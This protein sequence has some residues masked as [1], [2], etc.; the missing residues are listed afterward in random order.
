MLT[1]ADRA[2]QTG[3]TKMGSASDRLT[4]G[5]IAAELGDQMAWMLI[6]GFGGTRVYIPLEPDDSSPLVRVLGRSAA[7]ALGH[8]F[9]GEAV[10]IPLHKTRADRRTDRASILRLRQQGQSVAAIARRIGCSER[11]IYHVLSAAPRP[12]ASPQ[13]RRA[14]EA[15]PRA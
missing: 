10:D 14:Q 2:A 15:L 3:R 6:G 12:Q 5:Q 7:N 9:G 11:H 1:A 8:R 4:L 13:E